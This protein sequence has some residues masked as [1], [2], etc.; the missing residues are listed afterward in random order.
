DQMMTDTASSIEA[1]ELRAG[2]RTAMDG[3]ATV[4]A[5]LNAQEPW[6]VIKE[7]PARA[8]TIL[9]TAIQAISGVR[10]ALSPYLPWTTARLGVMLGIDS[11]VESWD[12]PIVAEG[13][14]LGDVSTLFTKLDEDA[15]DV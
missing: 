15:L 3:A 1:V 7:D 14:A 11:A 10:V 5:Y 8:A 9:W 13:S 6:R 12:R 4:N 2:L